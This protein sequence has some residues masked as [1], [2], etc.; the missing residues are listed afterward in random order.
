V[1]P[2][3]RPRRAVRPAA[4]RQ[5]RGSDQ[6][7]PT[8]G[9]PKDDRSTVRRTPDAPPTTAVNTDV[10]TDDDTNDDTD[11]ETAKSEESDPTAAPDDTAK[12]RRPSPRPSPRRDRSTPRPD[13]KS[14]RQRERRPRRAT[15]LD[16]RT[17]TGRLV[18]LGVAAA[19]L[20]VLTGALWWQDYQGRRTDDARREALAAA[21]A[22][23]QTLFS[24]DYRTVES[25]VA[26][27]RKVVT[28]KLAKEYADTSTKVV[29]PQAKQNQAVVKAEVSAASVVSAAPDRVVVLLFLNQATQNVKIKGTKLDQSRVRLTMV[30]KGDRWL[31]ERAEPL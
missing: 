1:V 12:P 30:R 26:A 16:R 25:D 10:V 15:G 27:G 29:I 7:A 23:A 5:D 24:Y 6:T 13:E 8:T 4:G 17:S 28:G 3:P 31:I 22:G 21:T 14:D 9:A 19:L 20:A 18:A 2:P 11:V